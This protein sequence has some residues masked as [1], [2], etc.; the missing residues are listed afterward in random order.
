MLDSLLGGA[1]QGAAEGAATGLGAASAIG[2]GNKPMV[3]HLR[4]QAIPRIGVWLALAAWGLYRAVNLITGAGR[5]IAF[6]ELTLSTGTQLAGIAIALGVTGIS[7]FAAWRT[8]SVERK[9]P[10]PGTLW[11][12][13][14]RLPLFGE[15]LMAVVGGL[16]LV[17]A[18]WSFTS[19]PE[20]I[21]A[22]NSERFRHYHSASATTPLV[23]GLLMG[24]IG[25]LCLIIRRSRWDL[26]PGKPLVRRA[27]T[28]FTSPKPRGA[29]LA[30]RW[31]DYWVGQGVMRRQVGWV[32]RG[33]IGD[34]N[35]FEIAFAPLHATFEQRASLGEMWRQQ[36]SASINVTS[37]DPGPRGPNAT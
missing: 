3:S 7:T 23:L 17:V 18:F 33:V 16:L 12:P 26:E 32:L 20:A 13:G 4:A 21:A 37:V 8:Y 19:I 22:G 34:K 1:L 14:Y 31:E 27:I 35:A 10:P 25:F 2:Q 15:W 28:A 11:F 30:L 6:R 9:H 29:E 36:L 5:D 24:S